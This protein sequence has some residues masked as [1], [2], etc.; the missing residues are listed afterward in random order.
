MKFARAIVWTCMALVYCG[1]DAQTYPV[2]PLRAISVSGPGGAG[3]AMQRLVLDRLGQALGQN[4]VLDYRPGATAYWRP[5][6][7]RRR[8]RMA[9]RCSSPTLVRSQSTRHSTKGCHTIRSAISS[10]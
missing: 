5:T 1:A 9:T 10:R 2:R 7:L 6:S 8:L 4:A 3:D